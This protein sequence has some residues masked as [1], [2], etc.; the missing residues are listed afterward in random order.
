MCTMT[1]AHLLNANQALRR[2][3]AAH[4][5]SLAH[6]NMM[7]TRHEIYRIEAQLEVVGAELMRRRQGEQ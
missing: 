7:S 2:S 1:R 6:V 4:Y 5:A 3:L